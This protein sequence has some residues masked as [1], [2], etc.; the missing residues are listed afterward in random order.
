MSETPEHLKP[1]A[2]ELREL[3]QSEHG[4]ISV[5]G[6]KPADTTMFLIIGETKHTKDLPGALYYD[7]NGNRYDFEYVHEYAVASGRTEEELRASA[8]QYKKHREMTTEDLLLNMIGL[9]RAKDTLAVNKTT[10]PPPSDNSS[11]H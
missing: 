6:V 4:R 3:L 8:L 7:Q 10:Q 5:I 1:L 2:K 11:A 9:T